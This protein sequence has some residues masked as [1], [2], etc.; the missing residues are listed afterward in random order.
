MK[1]VCMLF[2]LGI[3][4]FSFLSCESKKKSDKPNVEDISIAMVS[5]L[6][7]INDRSFNQ[8]TWEGILRFVNENNL[9]HENYTYVT[10]RKNE[11]YI[12]GLSNFADEHKTL[13]V[14]SG[15]EFGEPINKVASKYPNQKFLL[16]D[17]LPIQTNNILSVTFATEQG[18]FL[19][20]IIAALKAKQMGVKTVGFLGGGDGVI[21]QSFEAGYIAGVKTI[22]P[23]MEVVVR[24]VGDFANPS[25]GQKIASAMFNNGIK[26]IFG[27]AGASG[28]GLIKEAKK[29]ARMD[30]DI[31]VIGVDRDQYEDGIYAFKKSIILTSSLKKLDVAAHDALKSIKNGNFKPG[32]LVYSLKNNGVGLP[33]NNPNL[34]DEWMKVVERYRKDIINGK[35]KVPLKPQRVLQ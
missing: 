25:K 15:Y 5:N 35:I 14:G 17:A 2:M 9:P 28:N 32:H 31:W 29:R 6:G 4:A 24:Y 21:V 23:D 33:K 18:S 34:K 30:E 7:G 27:V 13:I 26:I 8:N 22:D 1:K 3:C 11:D 19:A 10:V 20:G 12:T 16:I